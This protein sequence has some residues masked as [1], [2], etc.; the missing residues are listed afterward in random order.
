MT[1]RELFDCYYEAWK[2]ISDYIEW[3]ASGGESLYGSIETARSWAYSLL[4]AQSSCF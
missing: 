2:I 1:G 3:V 4:V